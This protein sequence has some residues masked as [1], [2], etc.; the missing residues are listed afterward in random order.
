MDIS[1][2]PIILT[3][4]SLSLLASLLLNILLVCLL[5]KMAFRYKPK[6]AATQ[7]ITKTDIENCEV[8]EQPVY[9]IV[10]Q[11]EAHP[12]PNTSSLPVSI[13]RG[14]DEVYSVEDNPMYQS[15]DPL[16]PRHPTYCEVN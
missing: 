1:Q 2:L 13:E 12:P 4:I 5:A 14:S 11:S 9:S 3:P 8:F 15:A 7:S 10:G 16:P 6:M